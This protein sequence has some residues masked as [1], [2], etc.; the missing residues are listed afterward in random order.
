MG[1]GGGLLSS[2]FGTLEGGE[3]VGFQAD[4]FGDEDEDGDE[5]GERLGSW[6]ILY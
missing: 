6:C 4:R 5:D 3:R 1:V 2:R